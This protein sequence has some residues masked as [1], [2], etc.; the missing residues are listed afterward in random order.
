VEL[1]RHLTI[2]APP[3]LIWDVI[4]NLRQAKEWAPGFD[5]Y[6]YISPE[7]P[8]PGATAVWRY[9][10]GPFSFDFQLTITESIRGEALQIA[11][12][13]V[14]GRGLEVYRF[15]RDEDFTNVDYEATNEPNGIGRLVMPF[16]KNKLSQQID[17]TVANLKV[18]CER[19]A[20]ETS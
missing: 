15:M 17:T 18:Y 20:R 12:R 6:P 3:A 16:F 2:K 10:A 8:A 14:F 19:S 4:T 13:S 11:N 5:D 1:H 7:W 9:H